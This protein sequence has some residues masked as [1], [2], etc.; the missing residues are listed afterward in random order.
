MF[1]VTNSLS[2]K[3]KYWFATAFW[4]T[5]Y[6]A[7]VVTVGQFV[8]VYFTNYG[9]RSRYYFIIFIFLLIS[10]FS[11]H[12]KVYDK[13]KDNAGKATLITLLFFIVFVTA[14]FLQ[15][16]GSFV[17][18][19]EMD[20]L[21]VKKENKDIKIITRYSD[22]FAWSSEYYEDRPIL[23]MPL[24]PHLNILTPIDTNTINKEE[25]IKQKSYN[26]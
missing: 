1:A 16:L 15:V 26:P 25:W 5:V 12:Q 19:R 6:C 18:W 17:T 21:Y 8:P 9:F 2:L 11:I 20:I 4:I 23:K 10:P 13:Q 7:I 24:T 22:S 14:G 3:K